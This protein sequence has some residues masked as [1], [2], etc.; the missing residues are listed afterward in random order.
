MM[1][2]MAFVIK[3]QLIMND[4]H[5]QRKFLETNCKKKKKLCT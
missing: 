5:F 1:P 2:T 4:L 3:A